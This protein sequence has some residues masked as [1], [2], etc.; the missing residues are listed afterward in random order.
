MAG[1]KIKVKGLKIRP[2]ASETVFLLLRPYPHET[3]RVTRHAQ[4][5]ALATPSAFAAL[6][7]ALRKTGRRVRQHKT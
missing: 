7:L 3:A 4:F 1:T 6:L 5:K 2:R